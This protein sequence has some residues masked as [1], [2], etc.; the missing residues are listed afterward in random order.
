MKQYSIIHVL[1]IDIIINNLYTYFYDFFLTWM[2]TLW[3]FG[4]TIELLFKYQVLHLLSY[5]DE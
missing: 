3:N 5:S 4:I 2:I 1:M